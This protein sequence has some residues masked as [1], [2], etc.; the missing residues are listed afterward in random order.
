MLLH[1]KT[2]LKI[3]TFYIAYKRADLG[4]GALA[5]AIGGLAGAG[6]M[7]IGQALLPKP[8]ERQREEDEEKEPFDKIAVSISEKVTGGRP[9]PAV[10]KIGGTLIHLA[11]GSGVGALYGAISE[12]TPKT[13]FWVGAPFGA[14]V[15]A[16]FDLG[17]MPA[18]G[19]LKS[20]VQM[21]LSRQAQLL[22][23][24]VAY[25]LVTDTVRRYVREALD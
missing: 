3:L 25:G 1:K 9:G 17:V 11:V 4:R 21:P 7:R 16:V 2:G 15:W 13:D 23:M 10:E 14:S 24:H 5:G 12:L 20:P 8:N 18:L 6:V 22:G 19:C